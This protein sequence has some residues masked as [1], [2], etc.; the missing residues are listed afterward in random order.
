MEAPLTPPTIR[1]H[2]PSR[3]AVYRQQDFEFC[4]YGIRHPAAV[5]FHAAATAPPSASAASASF[6]SSPSHTPSSAADDDPLTAA[7]PLPLS[8]LPLR[9]EEDPLLVA[10]CRRQESESR[11]WNPVHGWREGVRRLASLTEDG[12]RRI[13]PQEL[14][15]A[16]R[17]RLNLRQL[18]KLRTEVRERRSALDWS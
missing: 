5:P 11:T 6:T 17:F 1:T 9:R 2:P 7:S 3:A 16:M 8:T 4:L 12:H 10:N 14:F 13:D 15:C 18:V